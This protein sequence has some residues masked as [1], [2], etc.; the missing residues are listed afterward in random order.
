M[1]VVWWRRIGGGLVAAGRGWRGGAGHAGVP[2]ERGMAWVGD[3]G[4]GGWTGARAGVLVGVLNV[5][6]AR[7]ARDC[8]E[9]VWQT[10][11]RHEALS[12]DYSLGALSRQYLS[13]QTSR[14]LREVFCLPDSPLPEGRP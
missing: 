6:D 14:T 4:N 13:A 11:K 5:R 9:F 1:L 12:G 3:V 8:Q 10:S 2:V 7:R